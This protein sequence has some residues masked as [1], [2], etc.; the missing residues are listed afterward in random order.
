MFIQNLVLSCWNCLNGHRASHCVHEDRPLYALKNKGR[1]RPGTERLKG[2][3]DMDSLHD[4]TLAHFHH[5][6]MSDPV[7]YR[8]YYHDQP[9]SPVA[10]KPVRRGGNSPT[11]RNAP[12]T[13]KERPRC[14]DEEVYWGKVS[15]DDQDRWRELCGIV[16]VP[17]RGVKG[18]WENVPWWPL[19]MNIAIAG[20][21]EE[22]LVEPFLTWPAFVAPEP[23]PMIPGFVLPV[24]IFGHPPPAPGPM[25]GCVNPGYLSSADILA[26]DPTQVPVIDPAMALELV[27]TTS[28]ASLRQLA[29]TS[30]ATLDPVPAAVDAPSYTHGASTID[31]DEFLNES[32]FND[33]VDEL[34]YLCTDNII[35]VIA[36]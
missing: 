22:P 4:G 7:L 26:I 33:E 9:P 35:P 1:P 15:D 6:V 31:F 3:P 34:E 10:G 32:A 27:T 21:G 30:T 23:P 36:C 11:K 13:V 18:D 16:G 2:K 25:E 5:K 14:T 29:F 28:D 8:Q 17:L 20:P 12:Y 24:E 19:A